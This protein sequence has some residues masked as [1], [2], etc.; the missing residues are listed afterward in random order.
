VAVVE[1]EV[2][3]A[4]VGVENQ[5]FVP[6]VIDAFDVDCADLEA[7]DFVGIAVELAARA[8]RDERADALLGPELLDDAEFGRPGVDDR[9]A[10][11]ADGR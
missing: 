8:E 4:F 10:L 6:G 1:A 3:E 9:Q 5:V 11:D 2:A 7:D